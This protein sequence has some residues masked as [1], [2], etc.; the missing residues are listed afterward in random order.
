MKIPTPITALA[1][2]A[3]ALLLPGCTDEKAD[4]AT[5]ASSTT[6]RVTS[7]PSTASTTA[8]TPETS[9]TSTAAPTDTH[10]AIAAE[11]AFWD[12]YIEVTGRT[13]P[14]DLEGLR[15]E[16]GEFTTGAE[17]SKLF[18]FVQGNAVAGRSLKGTMDHSPRLASADD[19]TAVVEDCID[20]M[21][22]IYAADGTR[23]D[24]D[25]PRRHLATV[26]LQLEAATWKVASVSF[27]SEVC[28][29]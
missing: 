5:S 8:A 15:V 27:G 21:T 24:T 1:V 12:R 19:T 7:A 11:L 9:P 10:P 23:V 26:S 25:D 17:T 20:D 2:L 16:L 4:R 13:G 29:P 6:S 3:V 28:D 14:A 18:E 22:G